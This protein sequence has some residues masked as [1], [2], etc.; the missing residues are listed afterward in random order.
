MPL[1]AGASSRGD[2]ASDIVE[3]FRWDSPVEKETYIF[4]TTLL[5]V[6]KSKAKPCIRMII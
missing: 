2:G 4:T 3:T 6:D 1:G 5:C